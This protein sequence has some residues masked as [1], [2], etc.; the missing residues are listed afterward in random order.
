MV[1]FWC[2]LKMGRYENSQEL[3]PDF[4]A[5]G[6]ARNVLCEYVSWRYPWL[7]GSAQGSSAGGP[8]MISPPDHHSR[9]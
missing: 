4:C 9:S 1:Y 3:R 8:G 7:S 2:P 6:L 5:Y